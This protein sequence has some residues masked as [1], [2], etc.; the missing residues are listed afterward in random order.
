M[1]DEAESSR[2]GLRRSSIAAS[3]TEHDDAIVDIDPEEEIAQREQ[4][5]KERRLDAK[6][7]RVVFLDHLLRELD[8]LVFFELIT[9]YH[10]D[11]SF[12]WFAARALIHGS[13][14]TPLPDIG[15]NRQHDEH[16]PF[17]PLILFCFAINFLLHLTYPAPSAGEDTRGY[18][19]GGL[20]ID[21]IGQQ[22]PTSKWKLAGLDICILLLQ[23]VMVSVHVK[24]RQAKKTLA[25]ISSGS[26]ETS[27]NDG[28]SAEQPSENDAAREQDADA[29]ERGELRRTDTLS[30]IGADQDEQDTLLPSSEGVQIDALDVLI[31]GQCVIGEFSLIDTLIDEHQKY[32]AFRQTRAEAGGTSSLSPTA[33]RQLQNIR[34]RFGA[35][36]G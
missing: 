2:A 27:A 20:M 29:E 7:K 32:Q 5:V 24:R 31:S 23:L 4:R 25:Q 14:L 12:F 21:F 6:R 10:L 9:L 15:L 3:D 30:D 11:C 1:N 28:E 22:G 35:G 16:K 34:M 8:T 18:L 17:L 36:G 33:L 13:L 19:H 26:T